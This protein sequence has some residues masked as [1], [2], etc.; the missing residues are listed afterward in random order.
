MKRNIKNI[1][2][3]LVI[4]ITMILSS[5]FS[6]A[7]CAVNGIRNFSHA[8]Y[9]PKNFVDPYD[10][11]TASGWNDY[12]TNN[13]ELITAFEKS[14]KS[15]NLMELAEG[16]FKPA[17]KYDGTTTN[18][19]EGETSTSEIDNFAMRIEATDAP[20]V[21][22]IVKQE[23]GKTVYVK[24]DNGVD[25]KIFTEKEDGVA[26]NLYEAVDGGYK[27]KQTEEVDTTFYFKNTS[28]LSLKANNWYVITA[29]VWTKDAYA[30]IIVSGTNFTSKTTVAD[31]NGA[32][33]QYYIFL[34]TSSD[35]TNSVNISFYYGDED[36]IVEDPDS[37]L[38]ETG[39]VYIDN[40]CVKTIN[41]TD[42]NNKTI[43][44][45][46][47]A[48]AFKTSY[49]AR[50]DYNMGDINGD[51]EDEI[52]FY[53]V[54]YGETDD[55]GESIYNPDYTTNSYYQYYINQYVKGSTTD[56][57][58]DKEL[59][60]LHSAYKS[61]LLTYERVLESKEFE[62]TK[63][64]EGENP[65]EV[66]PG[67]STFNA[68]NHILKLENKSEKYSLGLLSAPIKVM[69]FG[70]YR[71]S[72]YV[73]G[74]SASDDTTIK[75]ISYIKTGASSEEGAIQVK[76]QSISAYTT[77]SDNTNNWAEISFYI[78][79]NCY[80]D[81]TFQVALLADTESTVYF[82]DMRL[83]H[84]SSKTYSNIASAKKFDLSP[85]ATT[86]SGSITNGYFNTIETTTADPDAEDAEAP[87]KPANWTTLDDVD[88][89][90]VAGI[91][92]THTDIY[93][94]I[95]EEIGDAENP[96]TSASVNGVV[97][98]LP[99]TN[100]LAIYSPASAEEKYYYGYKSTDFSLS[101]NSV[102][103]ITFEVYAAT[104]DDSNF[105]GD[106]FAKLIYADNTIA[107]F[108]TTMTS[109]DANRGAWKKYT[110]VVR[111]GSTSRTCKL[112]IGVEDANGTA[113]FQKVGYTK[114]AEK[115]VDDEK[116]SV[117]AQYAEIVK[118]FNTV[119]L[120]NQNRYRFVNFDGDAFI[121]HSQEKAEDK[122]YYTSLSHSLPE[123]GKD[124]DPIVQ[125][126][127]GIVDT[128]A[129]VTLDNDPAYNLESAF[130]TNPKVDSNFAMVIYN[131]DNYKTVVN[132]N[133]TITLSSSSYY[134][135]SV[136]VKTKDIADGNGLN[137]I[138]DKI[139]TKFS[140]IN[141]EANDYG[142]L[143]ETN[144]YKQFTVLVKTGS[145]NIS[146]LTISYQLGTES[147]KFT[148]TALLT[149]LSVTKLAD[150]EAYNTILE[151]VDSSDKTTVVK[152]FSSKDDDSSKDE[153]DADNLTLATFFLVFSSIL[154][155]AVL[156]F[157]LV[158]I[159]IKRIPRTHTVSGKNNANIVKTKGDKDDPTQT[160][161]F[162]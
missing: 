30:T 69:Q 44:G 77:N 87:Y 20:T 136:Y 97:I 129:D 53:S 120:Q 159:Y 11:T 142:D 128:T 72:I 112:H 48:D 143:T 71:F 45:E 22:E 88:Q 137:I 51:F 80:Y 32:W 50:F 63:E 46:E 29:W 10:F 95:K 140:N 3:S 31:A 122:D 67:P 4:A 59:S 132:P 62:T 116:I 5:N 127:L 86:V 91:V 89:D 73:K 90:V 96:I 28:S 113:F 58:T 101:S 138:M 148:G 78:Q 102:Y 6:L 55:D 57:L 36:G 156:I 76:E 15:V 157:A 106:I 149:G 18:L 117:D 114:L 56:K 17:T 34:E 13:Q 152:D 124:E 109:T 37:S 131:G 99:K 60:N 12:H 26:D 158:M 98:D 19:P 70:Y 23:N 79:A 75:L 100:V 108:T 133:T 145:S 2:C 81:T 105:S 40:V 139:S 110:M 9:E 83:E 135:I 119:A 24:A 14:N 38:T 123:A 21:A 8:T 151:D 126:E 66:I 52:D 39:A 155:V 160:D 35:S 153:E 64:A 82:D 111:T 121:M 27:K 130:M 43:G 115:T 93:D 125:G 144:G 141:T 118:E 7:F 16:A 154:L 147:N 107:E 68:N 65:A 104:T 54:M 49:T 94:E 134:Q 146:N 162:V 25:D 103:K 85:S 150:E 161:G 42:F 1:I 41:E 92:P 61:G 47:N 33:K 84:I 74:A